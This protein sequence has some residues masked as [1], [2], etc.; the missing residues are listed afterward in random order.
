MWKPMLDFYDP[1]IATMTDRIHFSGRASQKGSKS[2]PRVVALVL[3]CLVL[4]CL[5]SYSPV[6]IEV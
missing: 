5:T 1:V 3:S 2:V 4:P 6:P